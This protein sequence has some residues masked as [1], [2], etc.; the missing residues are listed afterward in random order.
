MRRALGKGLS[1][2]IA[3]QY[4]GSTNEVPIDQIVPNTRQPRTIFNDQTLKELAASILEVG[5]LQPLVVRPIAEGRYELIAGERR[6]RASKIAGLKTVPV[7]VRSAGNQTSLELALIE[8]LQREDIN[9][10]ESARAYRKLIDEF[11]MTQEQ[12]SERVGKSRTVIANTVRLLRLPPRITQGLEAGMISEGH[13]RALLA[14]ESEA[15]QLAVYDQILERGLTV[16]DVENV[17]K[18]KTQKAAPTK[19]KR[20]PRARVHD[21][22]IEEGLSAHFG[23]PVKIVHSESSGKLTIEFFSEDDLDRI[24]ETIGFRL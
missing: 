16:R 14:F 21:A 4:E 10:L 23:T 22:A 7:L 12:V 20:E 6:L 11:G 19:S 2:L 24:L 18:P 3:E 13:A 15:H 9:A 17:A 1:Q 5:I 8:N